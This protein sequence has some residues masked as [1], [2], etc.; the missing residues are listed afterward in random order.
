[1]NEITGVT[2]KPINTTSKTVTGKYYYFF[3]YSEKTNCEDFTSSDIRNLKVLNDWMTIDGDT[4]VLGAE[5]KMSSNGKSIVLA[6]P[7]KYT[8]KSFDN[9][10]GADIMPNFTSRGT[11]KV[12]T[13]MIETD[14]M[15]YV[16][17]ITNGSVVEFKNIKLINT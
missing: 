6:W 14:Y 4:E 5:E 7:S 9:G 16:Y 12:E 3:G 15:V 10:V 11:V 2:E 13:G 8:L 1:M 17:P